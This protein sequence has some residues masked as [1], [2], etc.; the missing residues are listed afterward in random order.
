MAPNDIHIDLL[1]N[2][3]TAPNTGINALSNLLKNVISQT[4]ETVLSSFL[5]NG[6]DPLLLLDVRSNTLAVLY[7]LWV[8]FD[9]VIVWLIISTPALDLPELAEVFLILNLLLGLLFKT[10]VRG[11]TLNMLVMHLI[12]VCSLFFAHIDYSTHCPPYQSP[13]WQKGF[14]VW[15]RTMVAW[16]LAFFFFPDPILI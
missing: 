4:R 15:L 8:A 14:T 13:N 6:Q 2:Q 3:L 12:V 11:L 5:S 1:L 9:L 16:A 10:F 7:I